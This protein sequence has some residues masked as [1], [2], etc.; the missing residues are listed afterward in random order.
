MAANT[1][2]ELDVWKGVIAP[3]DGSMPPEQAHAILQWRFDDAAQ[4]RMGK[5]ADKN[6]AGELSPA[7]RQEL[8]AYVHV[9]QVIAILQAKARLS[10]ETCGSP[11]NV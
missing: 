8:E 9:G 5:L 2:T 11:G 6:N 10:L 3:Q 4:R 7:E 1:I